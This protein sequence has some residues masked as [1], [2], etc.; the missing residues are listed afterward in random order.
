MLLFGPSCAASKL[1]SH[2]E[3][4]GLPTTHHARFSPNRFG[5]KGIVRHTFELCIHSPK[6]GAPGAPYLRS[7]QNL[8]KVELSYHLGGISV[9]RI[10]TKRKKWLLGIGM[11]AGI[12]LVFLGFL[13]ARMTH[14][15]DPYIREQVLLY[16]Q[17][18]FDSEVEIQSVQIF[19]PKASSLRMWLTHRRGAWATI[20]GSG[21][22]LRYKGRHDIPAM[23]AMKSFHFDVDLAAIFD[24]TR[25]VRDVEIDGMEINIPPKDDRPTFN[26]AAEEQQHAQN[27]VLIQD[28]RII[29]SKLTILPKD[30]AKTPLTFNLHEVDL[31]EAGNGV[32]MK[33]VAAL[34]NAK[35]PGE[36]ISK[37]TFGPWV[38]DEPGDTP[39]D[40]TYD[41]DN[42]DLSVF[43]GISGTLH[44]TGTFGGTLSEL[45]VTGE[46]TVP[47]FALKKSG[48]P[49]PL[50]TRFQ[51]HVDGTNGDTILKPV[52]GTLGKTT[53]TTS[54][55]VIKDYSANRRTIHLEVTMPKGDL[56]DLLRLAM[57]GAPFMEGQVELK[58]KIDIPP[59]TGKVREKLRLDGIFEVTGGKFYKSS[60]QD[61][62]DSLS[63]RSQGQPGNLEIDE[64]VSHMGGRFVLENEIIRFS[65]VSFSVPGSGIDL[66]GSYDLDQD[67]LDFQ[68]TMRMQAKVSETMTGWK[69]WVMKPL[70]P[71]FSKQGA[72]TLLNIK[73]E[74]TMEKPKFGLNRG[75]K[76]PQ[77][78]N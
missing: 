8:K 65:P 6:I 16:L 78:T 19:L 13:A 24:N 18:R 58:T 47:N 28:V 32:A 50:T 10:M 2:T 45:D 5:D 20:R 36:I 43:A 35:P 69:H 72:G 46:A 7:G 3:T 59:L 12:G 42:A 30:P 39:L 9:D 54:G 77:S 26:S 21:I 60:I 62:I 68:G 71:F 48:N 49:V 17:K 70:D 73:V 22:V 61:Q 52:I 66:T 34:T 63:R 44:S 11:A 74:G 23:F 56:R 29:N 4:R 57:K 31:S 67:V 14:R 55:T 76:N 37:G 64:V 38:A 53:F 25:Q 33:Y 1:P 75:Q 40:G 41:F 51:V 27:S 15:L